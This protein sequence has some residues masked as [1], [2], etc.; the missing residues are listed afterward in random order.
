M[1]VIFS[2]EERNLIHRLFDFLAFSSRRDK[3]HRKKLQKVSDRFWGPAPQTHLKPS[4]ATLIFVAINYAIQRDEKEEHPNR[5][6]FL[7]ISEKLT[8]G[9]TREML[10]DNATGIKGEEL[11]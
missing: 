10:I 6:Y 4:E 5:E 11:L 3:E 8:P 9:L 7:S 1:K 2:Q